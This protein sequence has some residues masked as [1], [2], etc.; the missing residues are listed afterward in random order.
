MGSLL[1]VV[2]G[3][4]TRPLVD[5]FQIFLGDFLFLRAELAE[6]LD[7]GA[8]VLAE[9]CSAGLTLDE[10]VRFFAADFTLGHHFHHSV[11]GFPSAPETVLQPREMAFLNLKV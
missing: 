10:L 9:L 3:F 2:P 5:V 11:R 7:R 6:L 1:V 8:T 4:Y